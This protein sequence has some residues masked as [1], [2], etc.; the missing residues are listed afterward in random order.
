MAG[1]SDEES[2]F[3]TLLIINLSELGRR[4]ESFHIIILETMTPMKRKNIRNCFF[5]FEVQSQFYNIKYITYW[6]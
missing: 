6:L 1:T 5:A 2:S 4:L 3:G